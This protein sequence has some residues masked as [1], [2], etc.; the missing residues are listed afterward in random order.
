[1]NDNKDLEMA[2]KAFKERQEQIK[3]IEAMKKKWAAASLCSTQNKNPIL[4]KY[5]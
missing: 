1:M 4:R 5:F 2:V 3:A